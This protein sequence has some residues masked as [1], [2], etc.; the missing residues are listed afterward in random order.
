[1]DSLIR[2]NFKI[3]HFNFLKVA[4]DHFFVKFGEEDIEDAWF[5]GYQ[6]SINRHLV[7]PNLFICLKFTRSS[8]DY[9]FPKL[10]QIVDKA[11]DDH[12]G[13]FDCAVFGI[14][15]NKVIINPLFEESSP[16]KDVFGD[17]FSIEAF[18]TRGA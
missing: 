15:A 8:L 13:S 14:G 9:F 1:M 3:C 6:N 10:E 5:D 11:V 18:I 7:T 17:I 16:R 2:L 4:F 12:V